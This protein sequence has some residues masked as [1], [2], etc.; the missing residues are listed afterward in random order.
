[1]RTIKQLVKSLVERIVTLRH[2]LVSDRYVDRNVKVFVRG[3]SMAIIYKDQFIYQRM[4]NGLSLL[5]LQTLP[6]RGGKPAAYR[7]SL[8]LY[9]KTMIS[10]VLKKLKYVEADLREHK[11]EILYLTDKNECVRAYAEVRIKE[12]TTWAS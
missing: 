5:D 12:R 4:I 1:M 10:V 8:L 9:E 6:T 11:N 3:P 2:K 7:P